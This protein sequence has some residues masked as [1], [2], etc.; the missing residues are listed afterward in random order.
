MK[1]LKECF[2]AEAL[3]RAFGP[4]GGGM[5]EIRHNALVA[6]IRQALRKSR[7]DH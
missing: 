2:G 4:G 3:Q 1:L 7:K 5:D 6:N